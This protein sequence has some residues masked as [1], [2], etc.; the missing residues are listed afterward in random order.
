MNV[1]PRLATP[2]DIANA[3]LFLSAEASSFI[4]GETINV[5]GGRLMD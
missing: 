1:I 5:A 4:T 3:V 2:D